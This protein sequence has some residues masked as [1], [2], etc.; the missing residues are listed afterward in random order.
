[1]GKSNSIQ[2]QQKKNEEFQQYIEKMSCNMVER[3]DAL[4]QELEEMEKKHYENFSDKALLIEGRYSHLTTV[5]EWSLKSVSAIIDECSKALF[6]DKK[7]APE[8]S[9]VEETDKKTSESILAIKE[10]EQYIAN[11]AFDVVQAIVG[12]F[13]NTTTTSI[14]KKV[15]GKPIA[16]GMT[17]FIG[18]E[19][20]SFSTSS[21][22]S[23]ER[24]IQTIFVFKV[25]YSIAEGRQ[26][27]ILS[28]LEMYE[29]QKQRFR[30]IIEELGRK[31]EELDIEDENYEEKLIKLENRVKLMN[32]RLA[33]I[34]KRISELTANELAEVNEAC[35]LIVQ[36]MH[37][38]RI[39]LNSIRNDCR[40][41]SRNLEGK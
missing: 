10:R 28:D 9:K 30:K 12:G 2:E 22:L 36:R 35:D 33:K 31:E 18:V 39:E 40:R 19:N 37:S 1:M 24:I 16:P 14:E 11:A 29:N 38:R 20:N 15:D 34:T 41:T 25:C 5:S 21:F 7:R 3:Q 32:K 26:Q 27:S 17:M 8:G 6:G 4:K 23:S 13:N